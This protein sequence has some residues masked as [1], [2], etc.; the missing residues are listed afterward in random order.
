MRDSGTGEVIPLIDEELHVGK[1]S[2]V[3]GKIRVRSV[4]DEVQ[5]LARAT[6]NEEHVEVTRVPIGRDVE[7]RPE[8]RTEG[9]VTIVPVLE[10]ILVVETRL[11]LKEEL[12]VRRVVTQDEVEVPI[13]LR[14]QR[15]VVERV[16]A[17]PDGRANEEVPG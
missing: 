6:L 11:V 4:V 15:G 7:V 12:H 3:T 8:I 9:D 14:K 2:H 17:G 13:T 16:G 10:E 1:R 5:E